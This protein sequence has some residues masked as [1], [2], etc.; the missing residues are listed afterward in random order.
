MLFAVH[1]R[2]AEKV[3]IFF[4]TVNDPFAGLCCGTGRRGKKF[5]SS[6]PFFFLIFSSQF[7]E[8][9]DKFLYSLDKLE[10]WI[11]DC[12]GKKIGIAKIKEE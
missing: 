7:I 12:F 4:Y 11:V 5:F 2:M 6:P 3:D 8:N 9:I 10:D 1:R